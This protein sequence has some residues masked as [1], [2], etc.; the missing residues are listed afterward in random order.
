ML[1]LLD[2]LMSLPT[3]DRDSE[4]RES[5]APGYATFDHL[6]SAMSEL[7]GAIDNLANGLR[8]DLVA[9]RRDHEALHHREAQAAAARLANIEAQQRR[10]EIA[11]AVR[12]GRTAMLLTAF[13]WTVEH[14]QFLA[15]VCLFVLGLLWT[16]TGTLP[17]GVGPVEPLPSVG[18]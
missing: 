11:D 1:A 7:R 13:R 18:P 3:P 16:L 2:R 6:L 15:T 5:P 9:W 10:E 17:I 14:W 4:R 12:A 8:A